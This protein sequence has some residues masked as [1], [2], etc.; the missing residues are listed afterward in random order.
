MLS[1]PYKFHHTA[2][3]L[4]EIYRAPQAVK[5]HFFSILKEFCGIHLY[6]EVELESTMKLAIA[7]TLK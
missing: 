4:L 2:S 7:A 5:K 1:T 3:I 6:T